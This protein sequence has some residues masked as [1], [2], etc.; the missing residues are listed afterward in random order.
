MKGLRKLVMSSLLGFSAIA[1][2][3]ANAS[4]QGERISVLVDQVVSNEVS[5]AESA[6]E[7]IALLKEQDVA[8]DKVYKRISAME[9]FCFGRVL[10]DEV[11]W[12]LDA[13]KR[14]QSERLMTKEEVFADPYSYVSSPIFDIE[15]VWT[16]LYYKIYAQLPSSAAIETIGLILD[17]SLALLNDG[18]KMT[19]LRSFTKDAENELNGLSSEVQRLSRHCGGSS[20]GMPIRFV[21]KQ[22]VE[23]RVS[24]QQVESSLYRLIDVKERD[25]LKKLNSAA[26]AVDPNCGFAHD[27]IQGYLPA[28]V[29]ENLAQES[30][31]ELYA[32]PDV[33]QNDREVAQ[34]ASTLV[35]HALPTDAMK[36]VIND[37][38]NGQFPKEESFG[39]LVLYWLLEGA[40]FREDFAGELS[41]ETCS[42]EQD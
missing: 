7:L 1:F 21:F 9:G 34:W 40:T 18:D 12:Y 38:I 16:F 10:N 33:Y 39:L 23:N 31:A 2:Q 3:Y 6:P 5:L 42:K 27:L 30:K 8:L 20:T 13:G 19:L 14:D 35:Q 24:L 28:N 11:K 41:E 25:H 36:M 29:D 32:S 4:E 15:Y 26:A 37:I 22:V 17:G